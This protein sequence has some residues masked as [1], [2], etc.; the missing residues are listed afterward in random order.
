[1]NKAELIEVIAKKTGESKA[2][3]GRNVE[4]I[5][6]AIT[7]SL[8][9][10]KNVTLVGFGTFRVAKRAARKGVN[11]QTKAAIKIPAAKVPRFV[12]GQALK[13]VVA[14]SK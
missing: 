9:R 2:A 13:A 6:E 5:L 4:A 7:G 8:K 3:A 12:A 11:P 10:G 14:G 1:M